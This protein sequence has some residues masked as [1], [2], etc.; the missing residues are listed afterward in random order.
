MEEIGVTDIR[1]LPIIHKDK[2]DDIPSVSC[3]HHAFIDGGIICIAP[4]IDL[5]QEGYAKAPIS[6][7]AAFERAD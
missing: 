4:I 3:I 1:G 7:I 5:N 6:S 2:G